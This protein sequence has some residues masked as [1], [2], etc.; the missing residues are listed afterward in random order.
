M[1]GTR[2]RLS[3]L[4]AVVCSSALAACGSATAGAGTGTSSD[5]VL[6]IKFADC[7]RSHGVPDFPDPGS[8]VNGGSLANAQS[9]AFQSAEK[10]CARAGG[11]V[12]HGT[13]ASAA[14]RRRFLA[15]AQCMRAHG[16]PDFPDPTFPSTGG[17]QF[18]GPG[19]GPQSPAFGLA[20]AACGSAFPGGGRGH[21]A[22]PG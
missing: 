4:L 13:P 20:R 14:T 12:G 16:V 10:A 2:Y 1:P 9:P 17:V 8:G 3:V 11:P 7:M 22:G 19:V 18:A 6:A 5:P 15:A 21:Q